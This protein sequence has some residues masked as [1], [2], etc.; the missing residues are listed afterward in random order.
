MWTL[1]VG[2]A[3]GSKGKGVHENT[4]YFLLNFVVTK[5]ALKSSLFKRKEQK[6][7]QK[8]QVRWLYGETYQI[9]TKEIIPILHKLVWKTEKEKECFL[10]CFMRSALH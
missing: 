7:P 9:F 2:T 4:L 6:P 8:L 10:T 5:T 3:V 1:R